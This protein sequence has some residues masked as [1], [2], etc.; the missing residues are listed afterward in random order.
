MFELDL[1]TGCLSRI[2]HLDIYKVDL[3]CIM[4][5]KEDNDCV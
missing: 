5:N 3:F 4:A 1:L 2:F